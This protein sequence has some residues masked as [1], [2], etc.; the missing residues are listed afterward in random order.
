MEKEKFYIILNIDTCLWNAKWVNNLANGNN[1][2]NYST[3]FDPNCVYILD[4]VL[5]TFKKLKDISD[6]CLVLNSTYKVNT[7]NLIK[8]LKKSGFTPPKEVYFLKMPEKE[9]Q[10]SDV[11]IDFLYKSNCFKNFIIFEESRYNYKDIPNLCIIKNTFNKS[12]VSINDFIN[13]CN[14]LKT[15]ENVK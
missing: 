12:G 3:L 9:A 11:I 10:R 15:T 6:V 7:K 8:E 2:N 5:D 1:D 4:V 14:I 13:H